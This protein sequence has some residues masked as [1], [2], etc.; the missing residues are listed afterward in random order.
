[1]I[2]S[3]VSPQVWTLSVKVGDQSCL[4]VGGLTKAL[5]HFYYKKTFITSSVGALAARHHCLSNHII[6][7]TNH[8]V[9]KIGLQSQTKSIFIFIFSASLFLSSF[10]HLHFLPLFVS[11]CL[12]SVLPPLLYSP[13]LSVSFTSLFKPPRPSSSYLSLHLSLLFSVTCLCVS[14]PL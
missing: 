3:S 14:C 2:Y 5:T 8:F 11:L 4:S 10:L 13:S 6:I 7:P 12:S 1:M 9:S